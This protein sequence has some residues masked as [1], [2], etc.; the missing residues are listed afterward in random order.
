VNRKS[1]TEKSVTLNT[2]D[3][4]L[5]YFPNEYGYLSNINYNPTDGKLYVYNNIRWGRK[6]PLFYEGDYE[7]SMW[8]NAN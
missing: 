8:R 2:S 7:E 3:F 4:R 6:T 5:I 1:L